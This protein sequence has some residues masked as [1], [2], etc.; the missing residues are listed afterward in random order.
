MPRGISQSYEVPL[1]ADSR[2]RVQAKTPLVAEKIVAISKIDNEQRG[3]A[4]LNTTELVAFMGGEDG[5]ICS[6]HLETHEIIDV[7]SVGA[8]ITALDCLSLD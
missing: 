4:L 6:Y 1:G 7:W 2:K 3:L 8:T 5:I